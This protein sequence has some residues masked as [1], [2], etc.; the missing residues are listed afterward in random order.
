MLI[1]TAIQRYT[2][3]QAQEILLHM[4]GEATVAGILAG[5]EMMFDVIDPL[6]SY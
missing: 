3:N 5:Y 4:G 1:L 6:H 2:K